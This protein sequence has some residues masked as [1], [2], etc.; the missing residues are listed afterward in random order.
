MPLTPAER[1]QRAREKRLKAGRVRLDLAVSKPFHRKLRA[2]ARKAKMTV[3][4][5]AVAILE[6]EL[7]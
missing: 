4:A 6:L 3:R 7:G 5:F 1:Q 2:K